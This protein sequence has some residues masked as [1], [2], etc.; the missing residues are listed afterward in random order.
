MRCGTKVD[1]SP[2]APQ[3]RSSQPSLWRYGR[4]SDGTA[5]VTSIT[6]RGSPE[7]VFNLEVQFEHVYR[8]GDSGVLVHNGCLPVLNPCFHPKSGIINKAESPVFKGFKPHRGK[9][10]TNGL[11][12]NNKRFNVWDHTH[13]DI[14]VYNR[15]EKHLGTIDPIFGREIKPP[16][17]GRKIDL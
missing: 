9:T 6:S 13:G 8:V 16:V 2:A 5:L 11:S 10:K 17:P 12:G 7:P 3:S 1:H 4:S 15:R 14:E